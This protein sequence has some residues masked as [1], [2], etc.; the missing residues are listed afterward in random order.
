MNKESIYTNCPRCEK[1][2]FDTGIELAEDWACKECLDNE[3]ISRDEF[4][5]QTIFK[6][7]GFEWIIKQLVKNDE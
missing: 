7:R 6:R 1:R 5:L 3:G 2:L 4:E